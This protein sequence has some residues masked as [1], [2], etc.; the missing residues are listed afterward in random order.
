VTLPPVNA[1]EV[2]A[3]LNADKTVA[4]TALGSF[5]GVTYFDYTVRLNFTGETRTGRV[6]V[7]VR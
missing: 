2:S 5:T 1:A 4:I 3:V 6:Y 7:I